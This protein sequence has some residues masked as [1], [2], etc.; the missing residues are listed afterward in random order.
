[1]PIIRGEKTSPFQ[2]PGITF[3]PLAAPSLGAL[4]NAVWRLEIAAQT[5]GSLHSLD[6]EEIFVALSGQAEVVLAGQVV[7]LHAGDTLVV[8]AGEPFS[9]ANL[10]P[11]VFQAMA[12]APAGIQA[13][14]PG[15]QAFA[16]PWTL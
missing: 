14:M 7:Q 11:D 1:M 15:G 2:L 6:K 13:T 12:I 10:G 9:L 5:P 3:T 8:P 4:T 16:P